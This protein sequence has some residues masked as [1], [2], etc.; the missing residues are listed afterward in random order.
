LVAVVEFPDMKIGIVGGPLPR[1]RTLA[2]A[3]RDRT[4]LLHHDSGNRRLYHLPGN[5]QWLTTTEHPETRDILTWDASDPDDI[6][7]VQNGCLFPAA[8]FPGR[9]SVK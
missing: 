2:S 5:N 7:F 3:S 9:R 6:L 4:I 8:L 1:R